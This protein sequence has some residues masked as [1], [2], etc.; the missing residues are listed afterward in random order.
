M[1]RYPFLL[2]RVRP[3]S[4]DLSLCFDPN[5]GAVGE[6]KDGEP[7]FDDD[8]PS[9]ATKAILQFCEQFET[10]G[11]RTAASWRTSRSRGC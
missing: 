9:E 5:A 4:D 2:A 11:Q 8:Q 7:L 3:D 10:A 1:R 6:F